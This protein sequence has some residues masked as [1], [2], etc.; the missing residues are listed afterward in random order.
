MKF[1]RNKYGLTCDPRG[2][3]VTM[4]YQGRTWLGDV[5][6]AW[7]DEVTGTIRLDVYHFNGEPWPFKPPASSVDVLEREVT[8]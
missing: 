3:Q 4:R 8:P 6:G 2:A 1:Q 5:R 7:Y